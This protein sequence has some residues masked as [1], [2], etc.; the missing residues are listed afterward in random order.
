MHRVHFFEA[1]RALEFAGMCKLYQVRERAA[2]VPLPRP[3][4]KGG[5]PTKFPL[6][7]GATRPHGGRSPIAVRY[8][9]FTLWYL[10]RRGSRAR[11]APVLYQTGL[12]RVSFYLAE[13][14][15]WSGFCCFRQ[16]RQ[17]VVLD[18]ALGNDF[19]QARQAKLS[20][21]VS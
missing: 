9:P 7:L 16:W 20:G 6:N 14:L 21:E 4:D 12:S 1:F 11:S 8:R 3:K 2:S 5:R 19:R 15:S 18:V 13:G 10:A 17:S